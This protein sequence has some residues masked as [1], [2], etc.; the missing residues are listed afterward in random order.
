[1]FHAE[2]VAVGNRQRAECYVFA[3]LRVGRRPTFWLWTQDK[4]KKRTRQDRLTDRDKATGQ[5]RPQ[6]PTG[7][8]DRTGPSPWLRPPSSSA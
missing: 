5:D 7:Q 2:T 1:M 6:T 4:H 3:V 8:Q